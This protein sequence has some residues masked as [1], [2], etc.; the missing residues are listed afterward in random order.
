MKITVYF[1]SHT[2]VSRVFT[3]EYLECEVL[4]DGSLYIKGWEDD[5]GA[6]AVVE[7]GESRFAPGVWSHVDVVKVST[8]EMNEY[9]IID[10]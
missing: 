9:F 2:L 7:L 4:D 3:G 10:C 6:H 5:A 8:P 1:N